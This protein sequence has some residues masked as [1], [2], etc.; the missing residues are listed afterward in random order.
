MPYSIIK[1][2]SAQS[3]EYANLTSCC[4]EKR[5]VLEGKPLVMR[6]L[7]SKAVGKENYVRGHF[8][9]EKEFAVTSAGSANCSQKPI[10]S[11]SLGSPHRMDLEGSGF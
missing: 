3:N 4:G 10:I 6:K 5:L 1:G 7:L 8:C 2:D 11:S 9:S